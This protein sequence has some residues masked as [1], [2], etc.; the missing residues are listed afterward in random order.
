MRLVTARMPAVLRDEP[1]FRRLFAGQAFSVIG[2]RLTF[3]A[4]PFA[5][6]ASGGGLAQVALVAAAATVPFVLFTLAAGVWADR[7]D[8]R[9]IMIA[10]DAVRLVAQAVAGLLVIAGVS[11][12]WHLGIVALVYGTADA[13][14]QPALYGLM[15]QIVSPG[16]LQSA[17]A[18][19]GLSM[20]IGMVV[21]P[22]LA[23]LL[24]AVSGPGAALLV[25][26]GTFAVSIWFL[27]GLRSGV[28]GEATA[29][30]ERA[31][32]FWAGLRGG[33]QEVRTRSWVWAMLFG[34]AAY[35]AIVLP[36]VFALGPVLA[37]RE[38][39]GADAWAAITVGFGIGSIA[40][41]LLLL[42]WRPERPMRA[43][44]ACLAV[45][46]LQ[47]VIIGSGLPVAAIAGLEAVAA[48][49]VQGAFTLFETSIQE[50][51]PADA[52]SR[53]GAY[54]FTTSAGMIPLGTVVAGAVAASAG[55][56]ATLVGMSVIGVACALVVLAVPGIRRLRRPAVAQVA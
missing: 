5:V 21:G 33:W 28:A 43:A 45:A 13:F 14:F 10:S 47:A 29:G 12:W 15:P 46:S 4:L 48:V 41:Q 26:A 19:R 9:R 24:I 34:L 17:N 22:A 53:V 38:M 18:M 51:I 36:S 16:Q 54:D 6:L 42:R 39:G 40:G 7:L 20:A 8:R 49:A 1:Q 32:S 27:A 56:H 30:E 35:H 44:A 11:E 52:V 3:V 25:D 50:Q 23:G 2:D 37:E 55:L 31:E